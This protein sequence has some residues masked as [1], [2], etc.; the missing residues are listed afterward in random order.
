MNVTDK[1]RAVLRAILRHKNNTGRTPAEC[2]G[3]GVYA[4]TLV[5]PGVSPNV[6]NG[7]IASLHRKEL[8]RLGGHGSV[9]ITGTGVD[10]P[11]PAVSG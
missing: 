8:V 7:V 9:A 11:Y 6:C 10:I 1:E 2:I 3:R 5:V 4:R